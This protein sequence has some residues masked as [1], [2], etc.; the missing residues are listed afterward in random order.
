[1]T[2]SS[3]LQTKNRAH[4]QYKR[5]GYREDYLRFRELRAGCHELGSCLYSRYIDSVEADIRSSPQ[6]FW[7][8]INHKKYS[9]ELPNTLEDGGEIVN[10]FADFFSKVYSK[11]YVVPPY[12]EYDKVGGFIVNTVHTKRNF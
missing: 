7:I 10:C 5:T 1:R 11:E 4:R 3:V 8:Y 2:R 6:N 12:F 9:H